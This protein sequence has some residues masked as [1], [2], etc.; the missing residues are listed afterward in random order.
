MEIFSGDLCV[1]GVFAASLCVIGVLSPETREGLREI[2]W[3]NLLS[4]IS[5]G[6][7]S[8]AVILRRIFNN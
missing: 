4:P 3:D 1:A 6:L 8:L 7:Y 5:Q 2:W